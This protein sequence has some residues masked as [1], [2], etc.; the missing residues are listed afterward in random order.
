MVIFFSTSLGVGLLS[1]IPPPQCFIFPA[2]SFVPSFCKFFFCKLLAVEMSFE[3]DGPFISFPT[4]GRVPIFLLA[5]SFSF[6]EYYLDG[7]GPLGKSQGSPFFR[8]SPSDLPSCMSRPL[9]A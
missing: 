7:K 8:C 2:S 6:F 3:L 1:L 4:K 9:L 5:R